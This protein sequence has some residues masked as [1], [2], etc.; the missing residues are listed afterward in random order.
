MPTKVKRNE[1]FLAFTLPADHHSRLRVAAAAQGVSMVRYVQR[2]ID[3][4][5]ADL[6][7][8]AEIVR[9]RKTAPVGLTRP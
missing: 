1:K 2:L 8:P 3:R 5:V 9:P 6:P 7:D 4:D